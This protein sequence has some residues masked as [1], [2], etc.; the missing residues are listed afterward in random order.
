[1]VDITNYLMGVT[2]LYG[3]HHPTTGGHHPVWS[4][5]K[6]WG[7]SNIWMVYFMENPIKIDDL[8]VLYFRKPPYTSIYCKCLI[9]TCLFVFSWWYVSM[10]FDIRSI[11]LCAR[12]SIYPSSIHLYPLVY[13]FINLSIYLFIYLSI[14]LFVYSICLPV[15]LFVCLS[16]CLFVCL[17]V[18]LYLDM[19]IYLSICLSISLSIYLSIYRS[20]YLSI[21][22]S[23][24]ILSYHILSYMSNLYQN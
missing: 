15:C 10:S 14:C 18:Y 16:A 12:V 6:P 7:Y 17:S 22:L 20:I 13:L 9:V 11:C 21:Y 2:I 1:M 8:G 5:P 3:G 24:Y 23:I 19:C 4:F